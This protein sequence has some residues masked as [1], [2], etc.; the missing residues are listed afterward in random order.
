MSRES[1]SDSE[2]IENLQEEIQSLENQLKDSR[3]SIDSLKNALQLITDDNDQLKQRYG[4]IEGKY[5]LLIKDKQNFDSPSTDE[6]RS[7]S[8]LSFPLFFDLV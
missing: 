4:E 3:S 2:Q 1:S 8:T 6:V 5:L 7:T